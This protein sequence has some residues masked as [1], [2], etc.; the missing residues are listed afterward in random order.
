MN[1]QVLWQNNNPWRTLTKNASFDKRGRGNSFDTSRINEAVVVV[2]PFSSGALLAAKV[3]ES[4]RYLIR[5]F[6]EFNS[7]VASLV[8]DSVNLQFD[9][10]IQHD[11]RVEDVAQAADETGE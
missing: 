6:S 3:V 5:V 8:S 11:D 10:T 7:P 9:A 1:K 4:G 2:D